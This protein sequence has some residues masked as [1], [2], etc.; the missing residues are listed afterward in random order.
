VAMIAPPAIVRLLSGVG[1]LEVR[2]RAVFK[3]VVVIEVLPASYS[4]LVD[5]RDG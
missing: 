3:L 2:G 4:A 1:R 5:M